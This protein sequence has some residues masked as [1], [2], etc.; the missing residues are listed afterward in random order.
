MDMVHPPGIGIVPIAAIELDQSAVTMELT[1][2]SSAAAPINTLSVL[3]T[4]AMALASGSVIDRYLLRIYC[5][6]YSS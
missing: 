3:L 4:S 5:L 2:K 1:P 6:P